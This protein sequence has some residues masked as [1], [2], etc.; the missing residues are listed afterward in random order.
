[1]ALKI[2]RGPAGAGKSQVIAA[3]RP[4]VVV[5]LTAIWA[6]L[7]GFDR[8]DDGRYP[9]RTDDDP[10]LDLAVY[11]KATAVRY[12]ARQ[13]LDGIVTTS[14]SSP[15]AVERLREQGATAGVETIDPGEQV[16]RER[17]I[18]ADGDLSPECEKALAR[19]YGRST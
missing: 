9:V 3:E 14:S 13:G 4:S 2:L 16:A 17:L 7:R 1:M 6:A 12:A 10:A 15:E 11:L 5:D 18:G 19:W 8:D